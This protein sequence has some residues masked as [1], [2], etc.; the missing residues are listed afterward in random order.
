MAPCSI[1]KHAKGKFPI[2]A[3]KYCLSVADI[4]L[5]DVDHFSLGHGRD[6]TRNEVAKHYAE[7]SIKF[8]SIK[9]LNSYKWELRNLTRYEPDLVRREIMSN[10]QS[11]SDISFIG[12]HHSHAASACYYSGFQDSSVVTI[13][14]S[15]E[16]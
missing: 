7:N 6:A 8:H 13:D 10:L 3:V 4:S 12:H 16:K 1:N 15:G 14:G 11:D 2:N 5:D 9:D